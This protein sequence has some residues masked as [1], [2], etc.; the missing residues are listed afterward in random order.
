[1]DENITLNN[2]CVHENNSWM[3]ALIKSIAHAFYKSLFYY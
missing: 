1:M 2:I 3:K